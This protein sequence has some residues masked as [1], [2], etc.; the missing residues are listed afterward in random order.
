MLGIGLTC[1]GPESK[2]GQEGRLGKSL[3]LQVH[4]SASFPVKP[5]KILTR[6]GLRIHPNK[7]RHGG[8]IPAIPALRRQRQVGLCEFKD[9]KGYREILPKKNKKQKQTQTR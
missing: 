1:P 3:Q 4:S 2:S 9:S 5:D 6:W 8:L 7:A